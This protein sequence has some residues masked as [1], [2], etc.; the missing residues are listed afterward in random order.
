MH[1]TDSHLAS[2]ICRTTELGLHITG[3]RTTRK[4]TRLYVTPTSP[5]NKCPTCTNPG[6]RRDHVTRTLVDLP[7]VGYPTE[8]FVT[9]P[10]YECKN[11][12][13][14]QKIFRASLECAQ[15]GQK[16]TNRVTMWVLKA[17]A[18]DKMSVKAVAKALGVGWD[19]AWRIAKEGCQQ[20]TCDNHRFTGVTVIGVDEHRWSHDL[21]CQ[22]G[23]YVTV[24]VD[25]TKDPDNP[26]A[27]ARLL[28]VV[29][30]RSNEVLT[31]WMAQRPEWFRQQVEVVAMDGFTGYAT[32]AKQQ[33]P[34]AVRVMDPFHVARLAG[35][36]V[37]KCRRRLQQ[38]TYGRRGRKND[39]LYK[40]RLTLLTSM[41]F[42]TEK[43]AKRLE[44]LF[45]FDQSYLQ[46][47]EAWLVYQDVLDCYA[48]RNRRRGKRKMGRLIDHLAGLKR[49]G[50][51][52]IAQ[53][54]KTMVRR[55]EDILAFFDYG[56]SN[57]PVEAINGRLE[58]LR[59][60]ALGFRNSMNYIL[61]CLI[62][63]G[64]IVQRVHAL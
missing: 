48:D 21:F 33:F 1:P 20:L 18:V 3:A 41:R 61:R 37:T 49:C 26:N 53:L 59:G 45:G 27:P 23:G 44:E 38:E 39:P 63:S 7:I 13:C 31:R 34:Q 2:T 62:H 22:G 15:D 16:V 9:I 28:D 30:G 52:E 56:A 32:W 6:T 60:I 47:K 11:P 4:Y 54:A 43:K 19:L 50:V 29:E 36:K 42:L 46:L 35:D 24:I 5:V 10:R 40:N 64:G 57:G 14:A 17:M 8:L 58:H 25:M 51:A 55:R 12:N